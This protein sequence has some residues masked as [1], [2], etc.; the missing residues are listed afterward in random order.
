VHSWLGQ[1]PGACSSNI[2]Y[3]HVFSASNRHESVGNDASEIVLHVEPYL[4]ADLSNSISENRPPK[5][6]APAA[7]TC[8]PRGRGLIPVA[9]TTIAHGMDSRSC[10]PSPDLLR[11]A[12]LQG[13]HSAPAYLAS[14]LDD[15]LTS[16]DSLDKCA[17]QQLQTF[18]QLSHETCKASCLRGF[19]IRANL[20]VTISELPLRH[21]AA[22]GVSPVRHQSFLLLVWVVVLIPLTIFACPSWTEPGASPRS[23]GQHAT[24][25]DI[26]TPTAPPRYTQRS[27]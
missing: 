6:G 23:P 18:T 4:L 19:K 7:L 20:Y 24:E 3:S 12:E 11:K 25:T 10:K 22:G 14:F 16:T 21:L 27:P 8:C 13:S 5:P 15:N 26:R 1:R 2:E 17:L 9:H